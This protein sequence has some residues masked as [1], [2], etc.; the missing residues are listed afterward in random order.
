MTGPRPP[1]TDLHCHL[2]PAVDD[3]ARTLEDA[4]GWLETFRDEGILRVVTTPHLSGSRVRGT[5]RDRIETAWK[6][7]E[8][9]AAT[10]VP[11]VELS[12]SFEI[13]IDEP[14]LD[15]SDRRLGLGG[16]ALL[17]EFPQ[18]VLPAFPD[19]MLA[20]VAEAGWRPVLAHPERYTGIG[21]AYGW[22][23]RWRAAGV[24][25]CVNAG[26]LRG[27]H[28]A[29]AERVARRMLALGHADLIASD[30]HAREDRAPSLRAVRDGLARAG[31]EE[32]A[33]LLAAENPQ[34]LLAGEAC[35]PVPPVDLSPGLVRRLRRWVK[36]TGT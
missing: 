14:D 29:E 26:S 27:E 11:E 23:E 17:V 4:I 10:R 28:G 24:V 7:L 12:L 5:W 16:G 35:R 15:L 1:L 2:V 31:Y 25:L 20:G 6:E 22:I 8:R 18:L 13:R 21:A 33:D 9:E 32:A 36:G 19:R 34:A 3:G 30:H